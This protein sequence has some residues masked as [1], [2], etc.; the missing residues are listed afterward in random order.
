MSAITT[1]EELRAVVGEP[2]PGLEAKVEDHLND[3]ALQ[4]IEKCPFLVLSSSDKSGRV[5]AS[6]KGDAPGFL[7][8]VDNM[9][10]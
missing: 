9:A 10:I 3:F 5:D 8:V 6:P 7:S 2:P 4:F 1:V